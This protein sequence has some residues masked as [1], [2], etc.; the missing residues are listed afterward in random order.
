MTHRNSQARLTLP[1]LELKF[2]GGHP[3]IPD[4]PGVGGHA[5]FSGP[6]TRGNARAGQHNDSDDDNDYV[7]TSNAMHTSRSRGR[8]RSRAHS[9]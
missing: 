7:G 4:I 9:A 2:Y 6:F 3:L 5:S 1:C 8:R